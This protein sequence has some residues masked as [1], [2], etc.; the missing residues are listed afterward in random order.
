MWKS[1][2]MR[3]GTLRSLRTQASLRNST[4]I[5][6]LLD[7]HSLRF[8]YPLT[9]VSPVTPFS[10]NPLTAWIHGGSFRLA[11]VA[12]DKSIRSDPESR[13]AMMDSSFQPP[14]W[15]PSTHKPTTPIDMCPLGRARL[16]QATMVATL[17]VRESKWEGLGD[18]GSSALA[19]REKAFT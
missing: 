8:M 6:L 10:Q 17:E 9:L 5:P 2:P 16:F 14:I 15:H 7:S 19:A 1:S 13:R 11:R 4:Q 3:R 18:S 12:S